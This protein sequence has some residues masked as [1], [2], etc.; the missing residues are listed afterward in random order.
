[1]QRECIVNLLLYASD[2]YFLTLL[3]GSHAYQNNNL[4][5]YLEK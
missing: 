2:K 1:M 5:S 3:F 4:I